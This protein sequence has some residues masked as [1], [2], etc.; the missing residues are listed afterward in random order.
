MSAKIVNLRAARKRARRR[1]EDEKAAERRIAHG[2]PKGL[3][4]EIEASRSKARRDLDGHR[5][6]Q[7][8]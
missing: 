6:D 2:T 7:D 3:R 8:E 1:K 4:Q 5:L